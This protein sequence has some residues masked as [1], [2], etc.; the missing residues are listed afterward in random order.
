MSG[1]HWWKP[2]GTNSLNL[3]VTPEYLKLWGKLVSATS[4]RSRVLFEKVQQTIRTSV[5]SKDHHP[6]H[7][8]N[9]ISVCCSLSWELI[10]TDFFMSLLGAQINCLVL[11]STIS[12]TL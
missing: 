5:S 12:F 11:S 8:H 9:N 2:H 1:K 3:V 4:E 6:G 10:N 7:Q